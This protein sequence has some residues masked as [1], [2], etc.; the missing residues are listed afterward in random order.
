[1]YKQGSGG[2]HYAA[3]GASLIVIG[4]GQVIGLRL[5]FVTLWFFGVAQKWMGERWGCVFANKISRENHDDSTGRS[6]PEEE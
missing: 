5:G 3:L 4:L 6:T 2:D 1:L